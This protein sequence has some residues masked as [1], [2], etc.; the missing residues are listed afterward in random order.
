MP[1][2]VIRGEI[3]SS[4]SL[5]K[6]SMQAELLFWHMIICA[7]DYGRLDGRIQVLRSVTFPTRQDI[8]TGEMQRW[9]NELASCEGDQS[10]VALY[11]VE[12]RPYIQLRNWE[13]HRSN[14]RRSSKSK[15]PRIPEISSDI[16]GNPRIPENPRPSDVWRLTSDE[17]RVEETAAEPAEPQSRLPFESAPSRQQ[18]LAL[19]D[20]PP[21]PAVPDDDFQSE[22]D[23]GWPEIVVPPRPELP[24]EHRP[25]LNL[26]SRCEGSAREKELW[27]IDTVDQLEAEVCG[28]RKKL[29]ALAIRW[30]KAYLRRQLPVNLDR[31]TPRRQFQ[32]AAEW[33]VEIVS[34]AANRRAERADPETRRKIAEAVRSRRNP[35]PCPALDACFGNGDELLEVANGG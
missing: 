31:S 27:L 12:G 21:A 23:E 24:A 19:P 11:Q 14:G 2:R 13:K 6:V 20:A 7:D 34:V 10:P 1:S 9:L 32:R 15:F 35:K 26:L 18:Q 30:Y 29:P 17:G 16:R 28:E 3:V 5:S 8:T 22:V 25:L 33:E 4:D